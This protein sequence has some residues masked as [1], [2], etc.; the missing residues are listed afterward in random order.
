M[1]TP[2]RCILIAFLLLVF[3]FTGCSTTNVTGIWKKSDY[4]AKPFTSIMV[5][6]LTGNRGNK[7]LWENKMATIL[8]QDGMKTV[9]TT[10]NAFPTYQDSGIDIKEIIDYVNNNNIE[11]VLITRLVDTTQEQV[12]HPPTGNYAGS[13]RYYRNY[14]SYYSY[15]NNRS[16]GYTTTQTT[17]LLE[18]N[19]YQVK[20]QELIWSLASDTIKSGNITQLID[21]VSK[22]VLA[23][24][25]KDQLI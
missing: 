17:V 4:S 25:K 3:F 9:I 20:S 18:T 11:G 16:R 8:R 6:G 1:H 22:K 7:F 10:L 15:A 13:Y 2:L 23:T 24:L 14:G 21:S 12:Y 5:V 19:L